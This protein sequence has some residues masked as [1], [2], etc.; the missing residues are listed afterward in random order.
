[1]TDHNWKFEIRDY[2]CRSGK[3]YLFPGIV[4]G[5][6]LTTAG[7]PRYNVEAIGPGY[8]QMQHIFS[9]AELVPLDDPQAWLDGTNIL[10]LSELRAF[11]AETRDL[12]NKVSFDESGSMVAGRYVGGNG[13]LLHRETLRAN[14]ILRRRL[15]S[16][17]ALIAT[18]EADAPSD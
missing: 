13:G 6:F 18:R 15:D 1:M 12:I 2:V 16:I 3:S 14:D 17:A 4:T 8:E 9:E 5:R 10:P 11:V 7:A